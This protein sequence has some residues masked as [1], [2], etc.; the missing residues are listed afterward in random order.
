[1]LTLDTDA[2]QRQVR[3][4]RLIRPISCIRTVKLVSSWRQMLRM[5]G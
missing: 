4:I 2:E 1:M 5:R 3:R